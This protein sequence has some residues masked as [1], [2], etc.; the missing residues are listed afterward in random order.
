M[1]YFLGIDMGGSGIKMAITDEKAQILDKTSLEMNL[2][3]APKTILSQTLSEASKLK[4][5]DKVKAAGFGSAGD[6]DYKKGVL[7]YAYNLPQW[8]NVPVKRLLQKMSGREVFM[9]ND[10]NIA[11]LGAFWIDLKGKCENLICITLGTGIGG[12]I[13]ANKKI[14]RGSSGSA[15]EI[16]H[17]SIKFDGTP[18]NCGNIGCAEAYLGG[19]N[20]QNYCRDYLKDKKDALIKSMTDGKISNLTIEILYEAALK[21]DK[22][23][24]FLWRYYGEKLGV[25]IA[26]VL[27][28]LNPDCIVFCG[29]LSKAH[30]FFEKSMKE[31]IVKRAFKTPA[32]ICRIIF[33]KYSNVLGSVGAAMLPNHQK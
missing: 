4:F 21:K 28:I 1:N 29:G 20:F 9:D 5:Y 24:L 27:N 26:S 32:K 30:K 17:I 2:K 12:G 33:S 23:A 18:C 6:I 14:Y 25:L 11:A 16:G 31:E 15:G 7:R 10:A 19:K 13:I 22:E 3:A 8:K